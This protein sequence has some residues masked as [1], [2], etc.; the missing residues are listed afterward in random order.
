MGTDAKFIVV[1]VSAMDCGWALRWFCWVRLSVFNRM[2]G[3]IL[4]GRVFGRVRG[5]VKK[6]KRFLGRFF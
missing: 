5:G 2:K 3:F 6:E 1:L 4:R